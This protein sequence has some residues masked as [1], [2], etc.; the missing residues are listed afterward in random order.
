MTIYKTAMSG[1]PV[2]LQEEATTGNG[3]AIAIPSSFRK[4]ALYIRGLDAP[5]AGAV[6]P[7]TADSPADSVWAKIPASAITVIDGEVVYNFEGI[8]LAL[9]ARISTNIVSGSVTVE[10]I[11]SH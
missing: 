3:I 5:S 9:R 6:W 8:Y 11:G 10:Y 4:H 1:I 7:E 2:T